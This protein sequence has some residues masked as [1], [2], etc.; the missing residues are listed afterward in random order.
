M[1]VRKETDRRCDACVLLSLHVRLC[2]RVVL[3]FEV[4]SSVEVL[5]EGYVRSGKTE[6]YKTYANSEINEHFCPKVCGLFFEDSVHLHPCYAHHNYELI[7]KL[8]KPPRW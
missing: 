3:R 8:Q 2:V 6:L 7:A 1:A 5:E 4:H